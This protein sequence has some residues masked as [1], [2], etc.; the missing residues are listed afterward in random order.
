MTLV[1]M[2]RSFACFLEGCLDT[3]FFLAEDEYL[4]CNGWNGFGQFIHM[5]A[6]VDSLEPVVKFMAEMMKN[7]QPD[8]LFVP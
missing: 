4:H 3:R 7:V 6:T 8:Q 1:Q 5:G 2:E